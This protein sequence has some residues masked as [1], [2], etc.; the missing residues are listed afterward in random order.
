MQEADDSKDE[1][2]QELQPYHPDV[3]IPKDAPPMA[4]VDLRGL[5]YGGPGRQPAE[6]DG[7]APSE[8]SDDEVG[9]GYFLGFVVGGKESDH[10]ISSEREGREIGSCGCRCPELVFHNNGCLCL[11]EWGKEGS[12]ADLLVSPQASR[13]GNGPKR[14]KQMAESA[15]EQASQGSRKSSQGTY[16]KV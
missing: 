3:G 13:E 16:S 5:L 14:S 10:C 8:R 9:L 7:E 4:A 15:S 11:E 1:A 6:P 12:V 2:H